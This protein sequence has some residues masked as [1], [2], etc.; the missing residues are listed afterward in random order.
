MANLYYGANNYFEWRFQRGQGE[1]LTKRI[2]GHILFCILKSTGQGKFYHRLSLISRSRIPINID[3][4]L[5]V[6]IV[7]DQ[8]L[9]SKWS[10][11]YMIGKYLLDFLSLSFFLFF[12]FC[13]NAIS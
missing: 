9:L 2:Q 12:Y 3:R 4:S 7:E 10:V 5:I 11:V 8:E 1:F 13:R 6:F